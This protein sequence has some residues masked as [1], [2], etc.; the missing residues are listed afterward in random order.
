MTSVWWISGPGNGIGSIEMGGCFLVFFTFFGDFEIF[1]VSS[2]SIG[3]LAAGSNWMSMAV[4]SSAGGAPSIGIATFGSGR[5][6]SPLS[7]PLTCSTLAG[8]SLRGWVSLTGDEGAGRGIGLTSSTSFI[9]LSMGS[10]LWAVSR[11]LSL[12]GW[13]NCGGDANSFT[14]VWPGSG[15]LDSSRLM[16][17]CI[18]LMVFLRDC[19]TASLPSVSMSS[20]FISS[21]VSIS[22]SRMYSLS[23][24]VVPF[25]CFTC[26]RRESTSCWTRATLSSG[27]LGWICCL[28]FGGSAV[29]CRGF[30]CGFSWA[31]A[32]GCCWKPC[33]KWLS[34][35][36]L[37]RSDCCRNGDFVRRMPSKVL[38]KGSSVNCFQSRGRPVN[39]SDVKCEGLWKCGGEWNSGAASKADW[40]NLGGDGCRVNL[41][42]DGCRVN[43]GGD[44]CLLN[45][46]GDGCLLNLGGDGCLLNLGGDD[47]LVNAG[48]SFF[49]GITGSSRPSTK[50]GM[51]R[52]LLCGCFGC[53]CCG[54]C[55]GDCGFEDFSVVWLL[56][57]G[58]MS[59]LDTNLGFWYWPSCCSSGR[60]SGG[61]DIDRWP[62]LPL[63]GFCMLCWC[64]PMS[65]VFRRPYCGILP[66]DSSN[67]VSGSPCELTP[68]AP[69][70]ALAALLPL[71]WLLASSSGWLWWDAPEPRRLGNV[72]SPHGGPR[73]WSANSGCLAARSS[74]CDRMSL[75]RRPKPSSSKPKPWNQKQIGG[76]SLK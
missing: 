19:L 39:R 71:A 47:C 34:G 33:E 48:S 6:S 25:H 11:G 51:C 18:L 73:R 61:A 1:G 26:S 14:G 50:I 72:N 31:C 63:S 3:G 70:A 65:T 67:I 52:T 20:S 4:L 49:F 55:G 69:L 23:F 60:F 28:G 5:L 56:N 29:S 35:A 75:L 57:L 15:A 17:S 12:I 62:L 22:S 16:A 38:S 54:C 37:W 64:W 32:G 43:L 74:R 68:L 7:S 9:P 42:G 10:T 27:S 2:S 41:G 30:S 13:S 76:M 24:L 21:L 66:C 36:L 53:C 40:W 58:V 44:G 45:L 46:G 8:T 59:T